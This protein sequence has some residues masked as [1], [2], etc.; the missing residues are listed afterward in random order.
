MSHIF[1]PRL[2]FLIKL[3]PTPATS[4]KNWL[5]HRC[6]PVNFAKFLRTPFFTEHL[7]WLLLS[8]VMWCFH[9]FCWHKTDWMCVYYLDNEVLRQKQHDWWKN[10]ALLTF[11]KAVT[12]TNICVEYRKIQQT[13]STPIWFPNHYIFKSICK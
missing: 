5:W 11:W 2:Y 13:G 8:I 10:S 4:L 12:C 6:F 1:W 9:Y 3:Q 7:R